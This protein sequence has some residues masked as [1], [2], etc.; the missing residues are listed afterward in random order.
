M[1]RP[2]KKLCKLFLQIVRPGEE[3]E[4]EEE[5]EEEEG[6]KSVAQRGHGRTLMPGLD[7]PAQRM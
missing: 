5:D 1:K 4:E 2:S 3:E 7:P 6:Q